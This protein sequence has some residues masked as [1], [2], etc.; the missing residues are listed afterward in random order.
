MIGFPLQELLGFSASFRFHLFALLL[1]FF[2]FLLSL[3]RLVTSFRFLESCSF[4]KISSFWVVLPPPPPHTLQVVSFRHTPS[5]FGLDL[6]HQNISLVA[7]LRHKIFSILSATSQVFLCLFCFVPWF[8]LVTLLRHKVFSDCNTSSQGFLSLLCYV[9]IC[10]AFVVCA[11]S[12]PPPLVVL[13]GHKVL[14]SCSAVANKRKVAWFG[15]VTRHDSHSK[16]IPQGTLEGGRRRGRQ[17]K[18]W[19]INIK[20]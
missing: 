9:I 20:E 10:S 18:C 15:R 5:C 6:Q 11:I 7:L 19:L 16:T 2:F 13:L 4:L 17:R 3:C 14:A 8:S 12:H 1:F